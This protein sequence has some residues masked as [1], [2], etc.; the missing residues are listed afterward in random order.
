MRDLQTPLYRARLALGAQDVAQAQ[1]LR[2]L[3]FRGKSG[4]DYDPFDATARQVLVETHAGE[5][6]ATF[7]LLDFDQGDDLAKSYAAQFYD[8]GRFA[9]Q[10][11]KKAEV[12]RLCLHPKA[13]DPDLVRI[14]WA[15]LARLALGQGV[16]HLFG[17]SSFAKASPDVHAPALG[18][19]SQ[20]ALGPVDLR[21]ATLHPD[22]LPLTQGVADEKGLPALLRFYLGLGGW[23]ADHA[24]IDRDLDTLHIFTA[25]DLCVLP[26][27]RAKWLLAMAG[28]G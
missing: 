21:P 27:A 2:Q 20:N 19:L 14:C 9:A 4:L 22:S 16:Q 18:W 28:L 5:V 8:L 10:N 15:S 11:G 24:I 7:R 13:R 3:A 12:G 26:P 17:C 23:V 1:S 25:L 6:L